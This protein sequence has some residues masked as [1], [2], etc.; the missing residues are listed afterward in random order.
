VRGGLATLDQRR[1]LGRGEPAPLV[2]LIRVRAGLR[3][4]LVEVGRDQLGLAIRPPE[5]AVQRAQLSRQ[6]ELL[7]HLPA[8]TCLVILPDVQVT[9]HR[10]VPLPRL[11]VLGQ[12]PPL[13]VDPAGRV[14]DHDVRDPVD[15]RRV[16]VARRAR[17]AADHPP[18]LVHHLEDLLGDTD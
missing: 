8:R 5:V 15:Q 2:D 17:R 18:A 10:G 4:R 16:P 12:G 11:D 7:V 14:D 9:P 1:G 3:P 6:A 13:E